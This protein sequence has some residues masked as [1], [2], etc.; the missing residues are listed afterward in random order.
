MRFMTPWMLEDRKLSEP[1]FIVRR[2]TPTTQSFFPAK[3]P[4]FFSTLSAMTS[5][6][7]RLDSTMAE[8]RFSGTS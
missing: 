7:V 4:A 5:L 1:A 8:I 3:K 2:Y 6:R